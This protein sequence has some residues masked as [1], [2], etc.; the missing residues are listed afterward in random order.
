MI[1]LKYNTASQEIILGHFVDPGDG[2]TA[3]TGLTIANTD[4]QLWK[5][6]ATTL[7][8]KNSGGATHISGGIYYAVLDATDTN[9]LGPLVIFVHKTGASGA[10][11]VR[12]ECCVHPAEVYDTL[13]GGTDNLT[14]DLTAQAKLD[15]NAEVDTALNTAIPG[16]PTAN[17]V[18]E[19]IATMDDRQQAGGTGDVAA[20][21]TAVDAIL[22]DTGTTLDGNIT[23]IKAKTDSLTYTVAGVVDAN[24]QRINDVTILGTGTS[25]DRFRV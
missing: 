16:S 13:V 4:I 17:S 11:P 25:V 10:L 12:L 9:T 1:P 18:N 19:R 3:E 21:K 2:H 22:V 23:A 8:N 14:V 5:S 6:G 7:A 24:V 15:V 20:I